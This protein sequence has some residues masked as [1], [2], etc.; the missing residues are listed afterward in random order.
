MKLLVLDTS[1]ETCCV[2]LAIDGDVIE[3]VESGQ[4][5]GESLLAIVE[6]LL[7]D[8]GTSLTQ[9][10]AIGFGRGPGS[11]TSLR[12]GAGAVQGL[13][14]GADLPVVPV[15]SLAALAQGV[16]ADN[17][18]AAFDARMQQIYWG[19]YVRNGA[20]LVEL[21]GV[22]LVADPSQVP[23]PTGQGWVGAGSGWTQ[24]R[25]QLEQRLAG[26]FSAVHSHAYP[27]A[28]SLATLSLAALER[29][30]GVSAEEALPVYLR[31]NVAIKRQI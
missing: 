6:K 30:L 5:H 19:A 9:L 16:E 8:S 14:F 7:T 13:A 23:H 31:D 4:R 17:V 15:S 25:S 27:R 22:E 18:L 29:N 24:Y 11:F 12:I 21:A 20:G 26:H 28:R 2:G 3:H 10:D 1:T